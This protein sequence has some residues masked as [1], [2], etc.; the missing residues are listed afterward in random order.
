MIQYLIIDAPYSKT[1]YYKTG[2]DDKLYKMEFNDIFN[3]EILSNCLK[4]DIKRTG[5]ETFASISDVNNTYGSA[6]YGYH[7]LEVEIKKENIISIESSRAENSFVDI[8]YVSSFIPLKY[9]CIFQPNDY[10][11]KIVEGPNIDYE[12]IGKRTTE[13]DFS[14]IYLQCSETDALRYLTHKAN[15]SKSNKL[16][17]V[18]FNLKCDYYFLND[19][20]IGNPSIKAEDKVKIIKDSLYDRY[21]T[22]FEGKLIS[23][24][25][26]PLK[27]MEI[28]DENIYELIVPHHLFNEQVLADAIIIKKYI[29][30]EKYIGNITYKYAVESNS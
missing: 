26:K 11:Y 17:L 18:R 22:V 21:D 19:D 2:I 9:A 24:L 16:I 28:E 3:V 5:F 15:M 13:E 4:S 29:V 30:K 1:F 12:I 27:V 23:S 20:I 10:Y 25:D 14:G 7:I 6:G 8:T